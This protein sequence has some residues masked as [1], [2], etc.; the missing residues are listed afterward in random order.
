MRLL[1]LVFLMSACNGL[2]NPFSSSDSKGNSETQGATSPSGGD[3]GSEGEGASPDSDNAPKEVVVDASGI[4]I[5]TLETADADLNKDFTVRLEDGTRVV[6]NNA[7]STI[8]LTEGAPISVAFLNSGCQIPPN[9]FSSA[10]V[11]A[12]AKTFPLTIDGESRLYQ[13]GAEL[14]GSIQSFLVRKVPTFPDLVC[15]EQPPT[16]PITKKGFRVVSY[17]PPFAYPFSLPFTI[18]SP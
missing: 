7:S 1:L 16:D 9:G 8:V 2:G 5:G 10:L 18:K 4:V 13:A 17:N 15:K 3:A 11:E 6:L 12:K 14:K